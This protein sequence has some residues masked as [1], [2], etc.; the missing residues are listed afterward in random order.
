MGV[1][2]VIADSKCPYCAS[3]LAVDEVGWQ[4]DSC[5]AIHHVDCWVE[6]G[7]CSVFGCE[8]A[9]PAPSPSPG[10][11]AK[12]SPAAPEA[13]QA[14][15]PH[16]RNSKGSAALIGSVVILAIAV[17]AVFLIVADSSEDSPAEHVE[18]TTTDPEPV[19]TAEPTVSESRRVLA[20]LREYQAAFRAGD[21]T[22]I[23]ELLTDNVTRHGYN[24]AAKACITESGRPAVLDA[25]QGQFDATPDLYN[26]KM[27]PLNTGAINVASSRSATAD[28]VVVSANAPVSFTF[29]RIGDDPGTWQI[30]KIYV[31]C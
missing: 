14:G 21:T 27:S 6:S 15:S 4:C 3:P 22:A 19:K 7:G 13:A 16:S 9:G 1:S 26:F 10:V 11:P 24:Q 23:G 5:Q 20:L 31:T 8:S 29:R 30:R 25:F 28:T 18:Q 2:K 17:V 12:P